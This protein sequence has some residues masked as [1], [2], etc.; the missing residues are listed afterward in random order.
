MEMHCPTSFF[1][2]QSL[3]VRGNAVLDAVWLK[4]GHWRLFFV[5]F[6]REE[7]ISGKSEW[8]HK[9]TKK[10]KRNQ[11]RKTK[12]VIFT[13]TLKHLLRSAR[14]CRAKYV[15]VQL[16]PIFYIYTNRSNNWRE[17][18][19]ITFSKASV[20]KSFVRLETSGNIVL[21]AE[22]KKRDWN[23]YCLVLPGL[24]LQIV[25]RLLQ[26]LDIKIIFHA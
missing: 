5:V 14:R 24:M 11:W 15:R 16:T 13:F 22:K 12:E 18:F 4:I 1:L 3:N 25:G 26:N 8:G 10:E 9:A 20:K 23:E 19:L 21:L 2:A 7:K 6:D 17:V